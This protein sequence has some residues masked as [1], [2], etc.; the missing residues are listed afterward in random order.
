MNPPQIL[1]LAIMLAMVG[2]MLTKNLILLVG[3]WLL[4]I[5]PLT[6]VLNVSKH[7][8]IYLVSF[9]LPLTITLL[10][11]W[12]LLIGAPPDQTVGSNPLGGATYALTTSVRL[13]LLGGLAQ[14]II[15]PIP[16][17]DLSYRLYQ[18]GIRGDLL[19]IIVSAFALIPEFSQRANKIITARYSRGLIKNRNLLTRLKQ[20][21]YVIRPLLTGALRTALSRMELWDQWGQLDNFV[22]FSSKPTD[23]KSNMMPIIY[24]CVSFLW[25]GLAIFFK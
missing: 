9:I 5:L 1:L 23:R 2:S 13:A 25:L 20:V 8:F 3:G 19:I 17:D 18:I 4:F 11:V 7:H 14:V 10:F 15:L 24:L 16:L 22:N 21:P 6:K 12:Y